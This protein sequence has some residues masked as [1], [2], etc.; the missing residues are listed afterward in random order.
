MYGKS[1]C[2]C[3]VPFTG[4]SCNINCVHEVFDSQAAYFD[5]TNNKVPPPILNPNVA[6]FEVLR[7][8]STNITLAKTFYVAP[9]NNSFIFTIQPDLPTGLNFDAQLGAVLGI[10]TKTSVPKNYTITQVTSTASNG[11]CVFIVVQLTLSVTACND[12]RTCQGG[13]CFF[14]NGNRYSDQFT[15]HC[16]GNLTGEFCDDPNPFK[17]HQAVLDKVLTALASFLFA[18]AFWPLYLLAFERARR[19]FLMGQ[20]NT[21]LTQR[22]METEQ[23]MNSLK[24]VWQIGEQELVFEKEIARGAF[25][26]VHK[27]VWN[28]IVVAVKM[29]ARSAGSAG[30]EDT[31]EFDREARFMQAVRHSNIVL[32]FGAGVTESGLPFLV[33]EFMERG[34]LR[35]VLEN[36]PD[37]AWATKLQF[38]LDTASGMKHLHSLGSIHR[39]LKSGNL[40]VTKN[41]HVKVADFGTARL[42]I[43]SQSMAGSNG[44]LSDFP[45]DV[46]GTLTSMVGTPLWMAPEILFKQPYTQ[47]ADVYS[48]GVVLF[49]I[50]TQRTPWN[51]LPSKFLANQ[52]VAALKEGRRPLIQGHEDDHCRPFRDLMEMCW[53]EKPE[54]RPTFQEVVQH[55]LFL[56]MAPLPS[57]GSV[58]SDRNFPNQE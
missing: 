17:G 29:L 24:K 50:L 15:C 54:D 49:E 12:S 39:D 38:A 13:K 2:N 48:Y 57:R 16:P 25:G 5:Y 7:N 23:E 1:I 14:A 42:A 56:N 40:L 20:A 35:V 34:S 27:A 47:K 44:V 53:T 4:N 6:G 41:F 43:M 58:N 21:D 51:E 32:F 28:D 9:G 26:V 31:E 8:S 52:L 36:S 3:S 19:F 37:I 46:T 45:D 55:T 22:L 11:S 10:P 30:L 33:T 18:A